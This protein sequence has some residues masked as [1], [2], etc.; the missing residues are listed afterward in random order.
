MEDEQYFAQLKG[1]Y[2]IQMNRCYKCNNAKVHR[3]VVE[4]RN[5]LTMQKDV[6]KIFHYRYK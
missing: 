2:V 6:S 4:N 1:K 5:I 3:S